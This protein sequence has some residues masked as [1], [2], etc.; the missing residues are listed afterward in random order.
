VLVTPAEL[1]RD[2][3]RTCARVPE[4]SESKIDL[5]LVALEDSGR[6]HRA[7]ALGRLDYLLGASAEG[8][9]RWVTH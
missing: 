6:C 3:I 1:G 2:G 9:A 8:D 7:G 4:G 5:A